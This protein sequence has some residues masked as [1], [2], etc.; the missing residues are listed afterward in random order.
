MY[1][2]TNDP[3]TVIRISDG[4]SIPVDPKNTDYQNVLEWLADGNELTPY[5]E[6]DPTPK[7]V[8]RRQ[9]RQALA[10][11]GK[12]AL[13]Q[14][15]IENISDPLQKSLAQIEW[16]DS[17]HFERDRPLLIQLAYSIGLSDSDIDDLFILAD[18]L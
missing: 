7:S 9:A 16:D 18:T 10:L 8:T 3:Q 2:Q 13:V 14:P 4:A 5:S 15:A 6:L 12:L 1:Q 17:T 11:A